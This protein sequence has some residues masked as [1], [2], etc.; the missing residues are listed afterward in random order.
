[1]LQQSD[2]ALVDGDLLRPRSIYVAID[3]CDSP[4]RHATCDR[5]DAF[6][7]RITCRGLRN[8]T[9]TRVLPAYTRLH[10]NIYALYPSR[11]FFDARTPAWLQRLRAWIPERATP[12]TSLLDAYGAEQ[13][14]PPANRPTD[15]ILA[16]SAITA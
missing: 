5:T 1:M 2:E 15:F 14:D 16:R 10:T 13:R 6:L 8:G 3:L 12:D 9:L 4:R 7:R 11:C